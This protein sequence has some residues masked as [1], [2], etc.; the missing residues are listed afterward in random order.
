M[1]GS[2]YLYKPPEM[3]FEERLHEYLT[4]S[5]QVSVSA[6]TWYCNGSSEYICKAGKTELAEHTNL[7]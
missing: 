4:L 5:A 3:N 7:N 6:S 2:K 1:E